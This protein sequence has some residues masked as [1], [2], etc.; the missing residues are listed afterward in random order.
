MS[1]LGTAIRVEFCKTRKS[2]T[3]Q[4]I[5]VLVVLGIAILA[6]SL[7]AA[8]RRGNEQI[9]AQ[10]GPLADETG[11]NQLTGI[12]CQITAAGALLAFGVALAWLFGRE[13]A[14]ATV[15]GL[16][17]IPISRPTIAI[18]KLCVYYCW[19]V[20]VAI[21]LGAVTSMVGLFFQL[22][23]I[24]SGVVH[25]LVR[26]T[27]LVLL[28]GLVATPAGWAATLGRGLLPG[29]AVTVGLLVVAQVTAIASSSVAAWI[30]LSTPAL[31]ALQPVSV[32]AWQLGLVTSIPIV[33]TSFIVVS[34]RKLEL[35]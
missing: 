26:Q 15:S 4:T 10:L 24:N 1:P 33:F 14:D 8:A 31:W 20:L 17:A 11:W 30:P 23:P 28:T 29:I 32:T 16:F 35:D 21:A 9:L 6:G 5:T 18:A 2:Y 22:G 13:F 34:W 25:S 27:I 3:I 19:V 12:S 7:L